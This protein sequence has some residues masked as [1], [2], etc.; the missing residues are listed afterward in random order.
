MEKNGYEYN[1]KLPDIN[2]SSCQP[3]TTATYQPELET[4]SICSENQVT[5]YQ[6]LIGILCW[7]VE[8]GRIDIAYD[9]SKLSSYLVESRAGHI[10]QV[11][12]IFKCLDVYQKN[13]LALDPKYQHFQTPD[14]IEA[15]SHQ[16]KEIYPDE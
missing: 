9:V 7:V 6:N 10:V 1:C 3:F 15:K 8:L 14:L 16:M 2:Y 5:F 4:S 11:I 12:H 13:E